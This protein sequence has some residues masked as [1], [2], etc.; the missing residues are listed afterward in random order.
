MFLVACT[1][2]PFT[3]ESREESANGVLCNNFGFPTPKS[4]QPHGLGSITVSASAA[5]KGGVRSRLRNADV[6]RWS[7][8]QSPRS[9]GWSPAPATL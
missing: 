2:L 8:P 5:R 6:E 3:Q 9:L 7:P 1:W 4:R